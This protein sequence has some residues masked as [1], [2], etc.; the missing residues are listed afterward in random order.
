MKGSL[1][2]A[3]V[4]QASYNLLLYFLPE[5]DTRAACMLH[6]DIPDNEPPLK[7]AKVVACRNTVVG[8]ASSTKGKKLTHCRKKCMLEMRS[9][10]TDTRGS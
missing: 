6:H 10:E 9:D 8:V 7:K 3:H 4:P 2:C 1:H 5:T